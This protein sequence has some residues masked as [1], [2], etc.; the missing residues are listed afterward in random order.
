MCGESL[1]TSQTAHHETER[2]IAMPSITVITPCFNPEPYLLQCLES[3]EKQIP[4][5]VEK[6]IVMDGLSSDGT[7]EALRMFAGT[8]PRCGFE[9]KS[10]KDDGQADALNKAL[11][12]VKTEFFGWLNADDFYLGEGLEPLSL[13]ADERFRATGRQPAIVYGDY[14]IVD[15]AG[16]ILSARRQ[17]TFNYN[18]CIYSYL[19]IQNAAA[20]F[21]TAIVRAAGGF[22]AKWQFVMDYDLI[23]KTAAAGDVLHVKKYV[24]AFR[25]HPTSKTTCR[26][27]VCSAETKLLRMRYAGKKSSRFLT[28]AYLLSKT[29]VALRMLRQGC[30]WCRLGFLKGYGLSSF[31]LGKR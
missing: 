27:D 6:H 31:S 21:N 1:S 8:H 15:A 28:I 22:D 17:P 19:T 30:L 12:L 3:V 29:R 26:Q 10:E 14:V 23:L 20:I 9:W 25:M 13:A 4:G 11:A 18:D 24:S 2:L 7:V 5:V 16:K